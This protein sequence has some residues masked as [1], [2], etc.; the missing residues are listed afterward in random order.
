MGSGSTMGG[1]AGVLSLLARRA[2]SAVAR[3]LC[4]HRGRPVAERIEQSV[5]A[6]HRLL[7]NVDFD[8]RSNGE[9]RVLRTL[10]AFEPTCIFDV[11]G[12]TGDWSR[13]VAELF[14]RAMIHAFEIV[15]DTYRQ[16]VESTRHLP[17]VIANDF[18]LSSDDE[19]VHINVGRQSDTATAFKIEGMR[20]HD[21]YY[22]RTVPCRARRGAT[23]VEERGVERIDFLKI[24]VEGMDLRVIRGFGDQLRRARLVQFE[25][26]IF[27]IA[28]HDLL[29]DFC[30]HFTQ[31][32]FVVG[33][34]F[35]RHVKFFDYH[36]DMEN[37][38][39]SNYVAVR[40]DEARLIEALGARDTG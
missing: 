1:S 24:D 12:N 3:E 6:F 38:H 31:S 14:P 20:S 5:D 35:P 15:P 27:N 21:E 40:R 28:S 2:A 9:L 17:N 29:S 34:I 30:R 32:G 10:E 11:G 39:G 25:Y 36:F 37:F 7:N 22:G 13:M 8:F 23:Y 18:G 26:G 19:V 33:K 4:K 16:F